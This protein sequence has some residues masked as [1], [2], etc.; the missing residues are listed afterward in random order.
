M[1]NP[2]QENVRGVRNSRR[3]RQQ[4]P[5]PTTPALRREVAAWFT[6]RLSDDWFN[7]PLDVQVDD[8]EILIVGTLPQVELEADSSQQEQSTAEAARISRFR[9]ETRAAR[10]RIANEGQVTYGRTVSWGARCG[11]TERLFT[12]ASVPVM[13][14]LRIS[15]RSVLDTLI[16]AGVARSRSEA[17]AWCVELV[18]RNEDKWIADLRAAFE[19]VEAVRDRGPKSSG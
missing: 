7:S 14:R 12:T 15:Q 2:Q 16:D 1:V 8:D 11:S 3:S 10:M 18:G 6:G 9:E 4:A 19:H 13:T 17:L 5:E